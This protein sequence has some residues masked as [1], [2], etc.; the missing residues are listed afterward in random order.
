MTAATTSAGLRR[1]WPQR[2]LI[3]F[4][5]LLIVGCLA[6]AGTLGY[7]YNRFGQLPRVDFAAGVL[8]DEDP[9]E[10]MNFLLV[11]SD[12]RAF[13][14]GD[15]AAQES[16]GD[17]SF[18]SGQ[19]SDTIILIRIDPRAE[20][21]AMVSFPRDLYVD[22][23]GADRRG[24][25]NTAFENGPEQLIRT[26]TQNFNIPIHHYVQVDFAGFKGL[27]DAVDGVD[28]FLTSPV[29]DRA[30][31]GTNPSGLN[32]TDSGCVNLNGDQALSYVR[33]RHFQELVDGQW[34]A[35]P[36]GDIGRITRQQ[37]FIRR[38]VREA[39]S[40]DLL[41]PAKV[42]ELVDVGIQNVAVDRDLDARDLV[43]LGKRF[44][45]LTPES[46][47]QFTLP[48]VADR[49][50]GA[51]VLFLDEG[52]ESSAI[53]DVF[54]GLPPTAP[55]AVA[56]SAVTVRVLN[57]T[58]VPGQA[59]E[60]RD[61]LG[62]A[63]FTVAGVGDGASGTAV[64]TIRYGAGQGPKAALLARY[65]EPEVQVVEDVTLEGVDA[66]ISTGASFVGVLTTPRPPEQAPAV[67]EAT[68]TVPPPPPPGEAP[69]PTVPEC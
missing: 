16:F 6:G 28:V 8:G 54:R 7:F 13:T 67:A 63:G 19:R 26:V 5:C 48:V 52:Q 29:R 20:K 43:S 55:E 32:I 39:I 9:G 36:T 37:D 57:G 49:V 66:V 27:V 62:A 30:G 60:A 58:G 10:P 68:T 23:A 64:T 35:D 11:G 59:G 45:S 61:G 40:K 24:R 69:P 33:S 18:V 47:Q 42:N 51:S 25:I 12:T 65:F 14:E 50:N 15:A 1:T 34:K 31:D 56:P 44:R 4:N 22:V 21:A 3:T 38:A 53:L 17:Q 41:N 46:L 2:L